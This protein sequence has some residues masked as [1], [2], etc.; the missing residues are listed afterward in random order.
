MQNIT[1]LFFFCLENFLSPGE[2]KSCGITLEL[3]IQKNLRVKGKKEK[4]LLLL[5]I[6]HSSIFVDG[7]VGKEN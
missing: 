5:R 1:L 7:E 4:T 3:S 2:E 6:K